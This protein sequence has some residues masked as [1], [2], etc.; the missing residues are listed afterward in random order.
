[1]TRHRRNLLLGSLL[2]LAGLAALL[3][4]AP[5]LLD[6]ERYRSLLAAR[7]SHLLSREVRA[8]S[9]RVRL[10][11][12]PGAIVRG[13]VVADRA[14][15]SGSFIEA[16]RLD[17]NLRL[18]PLLRGEL[19]IRD[20]R[21]E[22]PRIRLAMGQDGWNLEDLIR[23]A[24]RPALAEPRR[25]EGTP[26]VRGQPVLPIL[27]AGAL[28]IRD[29]TLLF[30]SATQNHD[31]ARLEIRDLNLDAPA[32][33]P[34]NP[35]RIHASGRLPG[36]VSGSF[37]LTV[38][39]R[40][41]EGDRLPIE[42]Q[43]GV[44]GL[45]ASQLASYLGLSGPTAAFSGT[46]DLEGKAVGEWPRLD[47]QADIDLQHLDVTFGK[48][49]SKALGEKA[50]LRAKGRWDG[51]ALDLPEASLRWRNQTVTGHLHLANLHAPR[52]HFELNAPDLAVEP[53]V[54]MA[55]GLGSWTGHSS[56][57]RRRGER[58]I[59]ASRSSDGTPYTERFAGPHV[60]GRLR[61]G[62][63]H[64]GGLVLTPAEGELRYTGGL[65]T[66]HRLRGGFYG[67]S[68]SGDAAL[69]WRRQPS[70]TSITAHLDGVQ[71]EPLLKA[72]HEE[73]WR[74]RGT[75][76]L[77]S[78][79]ELSGQPGPGTLTRASGQSEL[80]VTGGRLTGYPPLDKVAQTFHP[81]L[82]GAGISSTLN[83]FDRLSAH[84]T[85][86]GGILRTRD[87][88]LQREGAK[89]FAAGSMNLHDQS[90]DFNVTARVAKATLEAKVT[91]TPSN[92]VVTPQLG[93]IEQRIKTEVGKIMKG[94]RG[95]ALGNVLR[96][97][98]P[99]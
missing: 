9:L 88:S 4:A 21:I 38:S 17:V 64:W 84:W 20:I 63:V 6:T 56:T 92:P 96:Q 43:L 77:D 28:T 50:W 15:W 54:A 85:L 14:P 78:R 44:R 3:L 8:Q 10:L 68:L 12:R 70:H 30:E 80:I 32:P 40:S 82:K 51:E 36:E 49:A 79:V 19:Q 93:R 75:M 62:A 18:L 45:E 33:L 71:T 67:G 35:L 42:A 5:L 61:S 34:L 24:A 11:P 66:I 27:V 7:A 1:M 60:E 57:P 69:D 73:R 89:L 81:L 94:E 37:D 58:G 72:L 86:D 97:L 47:L 91:G 48:E 87:L 52:I 41:Q 13:L 95:E 22:R 16:E 53:L 99:R 90:L 31:P 25:P 29:G 74:L 46:V 59:V 2:A 65:L 39:L 23:P 76:T 98:V 55:T 26:S 83:E